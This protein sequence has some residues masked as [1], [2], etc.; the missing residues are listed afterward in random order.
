MKAAVLYKPGDLRIED[1]KEPRIKEG[2][3]L[4]KVLYSLTCGT[5]LKAYERGHALIKYPVILG[6]EYVGE[7]IENKSDNKELKEGDIITGANSAPCYNCYYCRKKD[8]SLCENLHEIILGIAKNGSFSEYMVIPNRI[9]KYNIYK[10]YEKDFKRYASLEPL[11]CVIHGWKYLKVNEND[12]II[13]IGSGPIGILHAFLAKLHT[14][15]VILLGK[16]KERIDLIRS[17]GIKVLDYEEYSN[18]LDKLKN[19]YKFDVSIEAVGTKDTWNLAFDLVR[20]GGTVLLFGGLGPNA[21]VTFDSTK[22]HYGELKILGSF[23]HDPES[24]KNAYEI[25][26]EKK[27]PVEKLVTSEVKLDQLESALINMAKGKDMK[28]GIKF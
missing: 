28:V 27:I 21:S 11:A 3:I 12:N 17:M 24:V 5:D 23:H 9:A 26:K 16:H 13:V 1:V 10:I 20:K 7:V 15:N 18:N 4:I 25:I 14:P 2:E 8:Y 22:I 6:H 19:E